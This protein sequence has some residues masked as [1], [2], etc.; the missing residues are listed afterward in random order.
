M[1]QNVYIVTRR[2]LTGVNEYHYFRGIH[3]IGDGAALVLPNFPVSI[4]GAGLSLRCEQEPGMTIFPGVTKPVT[5]EDNGEVFADITWYEI[6][7]HSLST[8][9]ET[10]LI[11]SCEG[12]Y[13]FFR[14]GVLIARMGQVGKVPDLMQPLEEN[15]KPVLAMMPLEPVSTELALLMLSFPLLQIAL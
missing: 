4:R 1:D 2:C 8:G 14:G 11:R 5:R 3:P 6:G 7:Q 12:R 10:L 13:H 15:W 9:R